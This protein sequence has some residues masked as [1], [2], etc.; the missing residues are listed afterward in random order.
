MKKLT[1]IFFVQLTSI[2]SSVKYHSIVKDV[3]F[4]NYPEKIK[5]FETCK[6]NTPAYWYYYGILYKKIILLN[7]L[8]NKLDSLVEEMKSK[9]TNAISFN[10]N[11][12]YKIFALNEFI[13]IY[14]LF[15][16]RGCEYL[17]IKKY[18][19]AIKSFYTAKKFFNDIEIDLKIAFA[20]QLEK[21]YDESIR[22]YNAC[23]ESTEDK[24]I[25]NKIN[26]NLI[27]IYM[28]KKNFDQTKEIIKSEFEKNSC[29]IQ[30]LEILSTLKNK[31][32]INTE[33]IL[34]KDKEIY[35]FQ[36]AVI[37]YFNKSYKESYQ[38]LDKLKLK[39][40]DQLIFFSDVIY[41]YAV[42]AQNNS[43]ENNMLMSLINKNIKICNKILKMDPK[44]IEITKRLINL[45]IA[46][47]DY[48]NADKIIKNKKINLV[49]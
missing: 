30:L 4:D 41:K 8:S 16:E 48:K 2:N 15:L 5:Q 26:I 33:D 3:N 49:Y 31:H 27:E 37:K 20:K 39:K 11:K 7:L 19:K 38:L 13:F 43:C 44:N 6:K 10:S 23:K 21:K 24:N 1:F 40:L 35:N 32:N 17:K 29:N 14:N 12:K 22:I 25:L 46:I 45:Y 42:L 18:D 36:N 34:S 47:S 28:V 9:L